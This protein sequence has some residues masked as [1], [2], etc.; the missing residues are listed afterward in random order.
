MRSISGT[1]ADGTEISFLDQ[2]VQPTTLGETTF[3]PT[4]RLI[5]SKVNEDKLTFFP[6]S[7]SLEV[8][9]DMTTADEN[10]SP[11]LDIKNATFVYGRNK[12]NNP[13]GLENYA[14][15]SRTNSIESDPHGSRFVTEMTHLTQPALSLIH[16]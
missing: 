7:K 14:S 2:G 8:S 9:V 3:L 6:K 10:L 16:I 12:I 13:V 4:P 11:V 1:S 15:D 5:A